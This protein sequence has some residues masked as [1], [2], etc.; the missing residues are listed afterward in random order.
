VSA[1]EPEGAGPVAA[2]RFEPGESVAGAPFWAATRERRLVLPW[3]AACEAPHWFPREFC[4]SCLAP[5]LDW[6]EASGRG[7]V[8]AVSVMPAPA[9][10]SMAGRGPYAVGLVD[11][12]ED[13]RMMST[14]IGVAPD[15]VAVG[16][17]VMATWEPLTD[18]RHLVV[19][20]VE[21]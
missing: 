2:T 8:H 18:G 9:N 1:T 15:E 21:P 17:A 10:P 7:L 3:C 14:F 20:E 19:F 4:P 5:D 11:L 12:A 6:R 13:V 16:Q